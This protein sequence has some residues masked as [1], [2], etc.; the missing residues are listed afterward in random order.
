MSNLRYN[1]GHHDLAHI[2]TQLLYVTVA[3]YEKDWDSIPHTHSFAE[4]FYITDGTGYF[5]VEN[6][7]VPVKRDDIVIINPKMLHTE[8]STSAKP[9]EY[10][11]LGASGLS[12]GFGEGAYTGCSA[13]GFSGHKDEIATYLNIL[14]REITK[15]RQDSEIICNNVFEALLLVLARHTS[16]SLHEAEAVEASRECGIAK[17]FID[18]H[19]KENISLDGLADYTHINKYYLAHS[20]SKAFGISPINYLLK[21]RLE[22]SRVLLATTDYSVTQIAT[23]VGF[24]SPSYFS[25]IFSK[26]FRLSPSRYRKQRMGA[27]VDQGGVR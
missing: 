26:F 14:T 16:Y 5:Q 20:Y 12:F 27:G 9:M 25:Q 3:K 19:F 22:E 23:I 15:D 2:H 8:H 13:Y 1:I 21:K 7:P 6:Q 4:L 10:I 11:V 24:S 18:E 17:R